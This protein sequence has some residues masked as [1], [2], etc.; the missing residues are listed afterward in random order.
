MLIIMALSWIEPFPVLT[1][2]VI[3]EEALPSVDTVRVKKVKVVKPLPHDYLACKVIQFT[4]QDDTKRFGRIFAGSELN[5]G[6]IVDVESIVVKTLQSS[7]NPEETILR[8][9]GKAV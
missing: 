2:T 5:L 1:W 6:D 4:M 3:K 7:I 9:D 8:F